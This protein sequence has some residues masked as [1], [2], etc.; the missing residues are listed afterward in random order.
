MHIMFATPSYRGLTDP[1][2]IDSLEETV[3]LCQMRGHTT[4]FLLVQGCCYVQEARNKIVKLFLDSAADVLFFLDDDITWSAGAAM[5]VINTPGDIVAG[6][7]PLKQA[8]PRFPVVIHTTATHQPEQ[9]ADGCIAA[10]ALPT[11]FMCIRRSVLERMVEAYPEQR[12]VDDKGDTYYD[13]FPQGVDNGQWVGE[14]YAFCRLWKRL[15]GEMWVQANIDFE[16]AGYHGNFYRYLT[17]Q[18]GGATDGN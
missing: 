18:P 12:Y 3:N 2:F 14:D 11:G 13:L 10:A 15:G 1:G 7:Y 8:E 5:H 17:A 9:R 4:Q 6:I 16:H